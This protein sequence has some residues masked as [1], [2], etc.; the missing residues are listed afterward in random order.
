MYSSAVRPHVE[1]R[2]ACVVRL[3]FGLKLP[4]E[5]RS[6]CGQHRR[7]CY[8]RTPVRCHATQWLDA[9]SGGSSEVALGAVKPGV[10]IWRSRTFADRALHV[11]VEVDVA[12]V[13]TVASLVHVH[14]YVHADEESGSA[15]AGLKSLANVHLTVRRGLSRQ[16]AH[17]SLE[18]LARGR[19]ARH[20]FVRDDHS[21]QVGQL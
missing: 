15:R 7:F 1:W 6:L 3:A 4:D 13:C 9:G 12:I 11:G 10:A 16:V 18:G 2:C 14:G 5:A 20:F 8:C 19:P 21:H 17:R